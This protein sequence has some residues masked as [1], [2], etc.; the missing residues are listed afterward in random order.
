MTVDESKRMLEQPAF[1]R[2]LK[3]LRLERN[4]TQ[5]Q[6][7]EGALSVGYLSR[8]ESG[9][10][11][12]TGRIVEYLAERLQVPRSAFDSEREPSSLAQVL[13]MASSTMEDATRAGLD[14]LLCAL[15]V[16][17]GGGLHAGALW[18]AATGRI[19]QADYRGAQDVRERALHG[20]DLT[21]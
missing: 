17:M 14:D 21:D 10:R 13:A 20:A 5:A 2:R 11:P 16:P 6:L 1:G 15:T 12:P 4:L 3:A 19:R 8:L 7:A 9:A 18:A